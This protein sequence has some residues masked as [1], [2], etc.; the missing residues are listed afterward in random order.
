MLRHFFG[1]GASLALAFPLP[2]RAVIVAGSNG[3]GNTANNTDGVSL[4]AYL[5]AELLPAF[6]YWDHTTTYAVGSAVYL[7][8]ADGWVLS[9]NHVGTAPTIDFLGTTYTVIPG[10]V[11]QVGTADLQLFRITHATEPLPALADVPLDALTPVVGTRT[12]MSGAGRNRTEDA[13]TDPNIPDSTLY[14][15]YEGYTWDAARIG[16]RWGHNITEDTDSGTP[17]DQPTM[18]LGDGTVVFRVDFDQ[19]GA[20]EWLSSQEGHA[21]AGDSGGSIWSLNGVAWELSGIMLAVG[22]YSSPPPPSETA[23]FGEAT[24]S[25]NIPT[26]RDSILGVITPV[27]EPGAPVLLAAAAT[28]LGRRRFRSRRRFL[29]DGR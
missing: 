4:D 11:M 2:A 18:A 23:L 25:A 28:L 12:I 7:G 1:L 22:R 14:P 10:S 13:A 29:P 6:P 9:A 26:Y 15:P 24:F 16:P 21:S 27:P 8:T 5:S 3:G 20:G 17:G 19:P